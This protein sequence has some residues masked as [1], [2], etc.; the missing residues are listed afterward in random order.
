MN[1]A[2]MTIVKAY[3]TRN[4]QLI[5]LVP[6]WLDYDETL[7]DDLIAIA[8]EPLYTRLC[9]DIADISFEIDGSRDQLPHYQTTKPRIRAG[10]R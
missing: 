7:V 6:I 4:R 2:G 8:A 1:M 10:D 9:G 3:S 5:A